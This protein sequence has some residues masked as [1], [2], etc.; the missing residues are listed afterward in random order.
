MDILFNNKGEFTVI[1]IKKGFT[2]EERIK[3]ILDREVPVTIAVINEYLKRVVPFSQEG[4][5]LRLLLMEEIV[6]NQVSQIRL[7]GKVDLQIIQT[8]DDIIRVYKELRDKPILVPK[9]L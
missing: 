4:E 3:Y 6:K 8:C 7:R 5:Y 9:S 1:P 2:R